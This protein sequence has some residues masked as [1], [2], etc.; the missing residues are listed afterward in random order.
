MHKHTYLHIIVANTHTHS[1]T[2]TNREQYVYWTDVST[3]TI[4]RA[5]MDGSETTVL[6]STNI[7]IP[8]TQVIRS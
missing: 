7:G 2:H 4:S 8:G 6:L 5:R 1:H 3:R